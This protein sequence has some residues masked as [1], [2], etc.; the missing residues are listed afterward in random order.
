MQNDLLSEDIIHY[1]SKKWQE[2]YQIFFE[3]DY[4]QVF[5][6]NLSLVFNNTYPNERL[7]YFKDE[8]IPDWNEIKKEIHAKKSAL[9]IFTYSENEKWVKLIEA[10]PFHYLLLLL[11]QRL[12]SASITDKRA[13]PPLQSTL[14]KNSLLPYNSQISRATR[15]WEKHAGRH[16]DNFWGDVKGSPLEKEMHVKQLL[17]K[18]LKEKTWWNVFYHYKHGVVYEIRIPSG[19]GVRWSEGGEKLIGFLEPFLEE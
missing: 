6:Q 10:L 9:E 19:H 12:T 3:E 15:A 4:F 8:I 7:P 5:L 13:I 17:E 16:I 14:L 2:E 11:G 18:M 1:F